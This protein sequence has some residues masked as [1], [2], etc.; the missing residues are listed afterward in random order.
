MK[1]CL[2][3]AILFLYFNLLQA[4]SGQLDTSFGIGGIITSDIGVNDPDIN[5]DQSG[6]RVLINQEGDLFFICGNPFLN[7]KFVSK[8]NNE[9]R[10]DV[11][12]GNN[13]Y[14]TTL[15]LSGYSPSGIQKD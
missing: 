2:L 11:S 13:G 4:Q 7:Y 3:L 5:N 10:P 1:K 12:Y 15:N 9:G 8:K 6:E 14:S